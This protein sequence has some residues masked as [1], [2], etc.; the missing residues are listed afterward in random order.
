M[1]FHT[2]IDSAHPTQGPGQYTVTQARETLLNLAKESSRKSVPDFP[3]PR[4]EVKNWVEV[5][6]KLRKDASKK[7]QD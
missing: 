4:A 2:F 3:H 5:K 6:N 7:Q 1:L